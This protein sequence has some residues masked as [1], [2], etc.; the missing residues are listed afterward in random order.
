MIDINSIAF[1]CTKEDIIERFKLE[2]QGRG[3]TIN[4]AEAI[5][6]YCLENLWKFIDKQIA[7]VEEDQ[8]E[9]Q[10]QDRGQE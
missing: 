1:I 2:H 6:S 9:S 3:P 7:S 8:E 10:I 4:E 5:V